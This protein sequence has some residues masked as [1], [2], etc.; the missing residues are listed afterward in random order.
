MRNLIKRGLA[1]ITKNT[2]VYERFDY[3]YDP[4]TVLS[5]RWVAHYLIYKKFLEH[6]KN[7]PTLD[8]CCGS[9]AGT[10]FIA[11]TLKVNVFGIDYSDKAIEY[12]RKHNATE[13]T[14]YSVMDLHK[15]LNL[16]G[17]LV[18]NRKIKQVFFVE[19]IEHINDYYVVLDTLLENGVERIFVSTPKEEEDVD[20][21]GYHVN[22]LTPSKITKLK[23]RYDVTI[24]EY[25]KFVDLTSIDKEN[26]MQTYFTS[27]DKEGLNYL[28]I[29]KVK[30]NSLED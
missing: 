17:Q 8:L 9:G 24:L 20:I 26:Y 2:G 19:S 22:P 16:L 23:E 13:L 10:K 7:V 1:K 6:A 4:K 25:V 11:E 29:I 18:K 12:S 15:Q 5:S 3:T 21:H 14:E 30:N 28:F 27:N